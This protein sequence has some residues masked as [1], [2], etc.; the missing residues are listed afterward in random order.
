LA[1]SPMS[2]QSSFFFT[3]TVS[4]FRFLL[5]TSSFL[6]SFL[7]AWISSEMTQA[8]AKKRTLAFG[9]V[10]SSRRLLSIIDY[11]REHRRAHGQPTAAVSATAPLEL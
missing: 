3:D 6:L 8:Q 11:R 10:I 2:A 5:S 1:A 9:V 4:T 7:L